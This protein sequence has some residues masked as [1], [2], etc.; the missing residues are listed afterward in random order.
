MRAHQILCQERPPDL[1]RFQGSVSPNPR[2]DQGPP[3]ISPKPTHCSYTGL[4]LDKFIG[5]VVISRV[6]TSSGNR[7]KPGKSLKKSSMHGKIMELEIN[8]NNHVKIME[9]CEI[10]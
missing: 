7:G 10:I 9:F 4:P 5:K 6:P 3:P 1:Q 8:L 2:A